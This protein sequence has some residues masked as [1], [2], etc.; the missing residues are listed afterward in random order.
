MYEIAA[1]L[2]K[3]VSKGVAKPK[4]DAGQQKQ[5]IV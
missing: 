5:D 4:Y 1:Q 3:S 2:Q